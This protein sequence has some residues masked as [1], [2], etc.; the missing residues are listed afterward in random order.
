MID[1]TQELG[2]ELYP[3]AKGRLSL[4]CSGKKA[5][6]KPCEGE[7]HARFDE[8]ELVERVGL[9]LPV[10]YSTRNTCGVAA[11]SAGVL[12]GPSELRW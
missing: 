7:P 8:G 6:G 2:E 12:T 11:P 10:L 1:N 3:D 9:A 5:I 4:E